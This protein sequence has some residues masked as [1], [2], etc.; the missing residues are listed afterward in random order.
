MNKKYLT[1]YWLDLLTYIVLPFVTVVASIN[2]VKGLLYSAFSFEFLLAL[3]AELV[4]ICLY[5]LTFITSYKISK[6]AYFFFRVLVYATAL[7]AA[8]DFTLSQV[9]GL[10]PILAFLVY[11]LIVSIVWIY[12]NEIYFKKRK[13][14]FAK[15]SRL[16]FL[17]PVNKSTK[18]EDKKKSKKK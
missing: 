11:F 15:E 4:F 13:H 12:P 7:K 1:T 17:L 5:V 3:I 14:L 9:T 16:R 10:E 18:K 8:L 6:P 2:V